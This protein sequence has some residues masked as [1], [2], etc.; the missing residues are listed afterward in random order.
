ML[1]PAAHASIATEPTMRTPHSVF[2]SL[3]ACLFVAITL[4]LPATALAEP[5][6]L[7]FGT[8]LPQNSPW[9]RQLKK[10]AADVAKDTGGELTMDFQWN[11]QAGDE[12]LMV[13]KIRVGQLDG[14]IVSSAGLAQ[15]GVVDAL[16]FQLPGLFRDWRKLDAVRTAVTAELNTQ[17]YAKGFIVL[18]WGDAGAMKAMSVGFEVRRP[19]DLRGK[20]LFVLADDPVEPALL[21]AIGGI[22]PRSISLGEILPGMANGA[23]TVITASPLLAEQLQWASRITHVCSQTFAFGVGGFLAS[24][25]R[26]QALPQRFKDIMAAR[27]AELEGR[28]EP[29]VRDMDTQA[30]AR[31]KATKTVYDLTDSEKA[32]WQDVFDRV[33][34]RLRGAVFS[35]ALFDRVVSLARE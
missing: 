7:K 35:P 9:G 29:M 4:V 8:L 28:L 1:S 14:A 23:I 27:G 18:G 26:M 12:A 24:L 33:A 21:S 13:Q 16:L 25:P 11:A 19:L 3:L 22:V 2:R 6:T 20:G 5:T 31:M 17:F 32:E 30:F 10:W 34:L 15:T